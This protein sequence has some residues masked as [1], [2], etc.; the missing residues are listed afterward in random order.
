MI[1]DINMEFD[2]LYMDEWKDNEF[3]GGSDNNRIDALKE[4]YDKLTEYWR[5]F[6]N[7]I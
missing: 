7:L 2:F 3:P 5:Y 4:Q 1:P 6:N